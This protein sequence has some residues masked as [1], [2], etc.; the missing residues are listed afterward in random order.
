MKLLQILCVV[1]LGVLIGLPFLQVIMR[2][3]FGSAIVGLEEL[4]RFMLICTVFVA[5]PLVVMRDENIVMGELRG[6]LPDKLRRGLDL[7]IALL[8]VA[9][10]GLIA[11]VTAMSISDNMNNA[12]PTLGIPFWVFLGACFVG[13]AGACLIHVLHLRRAPKHDTVT[14]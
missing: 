14:L 4:T 2:D 1:L 6:A 9:A 12:T 13:F 11:G 5:Y 7:G 3:V 8:S 10:C